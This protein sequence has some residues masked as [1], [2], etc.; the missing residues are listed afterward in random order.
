M[1]TGLSSYKNIIMLFS[2][3]IVKILTICPTSTPLQFFLVASHLTLILEDF[4]L[5]KIRQHPIKS[6]VRLLPTWQ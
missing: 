4:P 2:N 5:S 1:M 6:G 3:Y